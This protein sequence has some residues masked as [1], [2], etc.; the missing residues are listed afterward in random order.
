M[1]RRIFFVGLLFAAILVIPGCSEPL[2]FGPTEAQK[3]TA[4][5]TADLARKV[6]A[7]GT[8][9]GSPASKKLV[10]GTRAGAYYMGPPKT[11]ADI[12]QFDT[13]A[14]LAEQQ[15]QARPD[16]WAM[17]DNALELGVGIAA[18]FGGAGGAALIRR[19]KILRQKGK[20]LEQVVKG[21]DLFK[22]KKGNGTSTTENFTSAH[23]D[24]QDT[25]TK[26][27]VAILRAGT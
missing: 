8:I 6:D 1:N 11:P 14:P 18:I 21:N 23:N 24:V 3:Q 22:T 16:A 5:L 26:K 20:A 10:R 2:R 27:L 19:L 9:P 15:A 13:I 17:A 4:W 25:E 12:E 7:D